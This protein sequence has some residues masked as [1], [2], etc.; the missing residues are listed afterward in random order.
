MTS[1]RA[2][3]IGDDCG[4]SESNEFDGWKNIIIN[5]GQRVVTYCETD[6]RPPPTV[7]ASKCQFI[8]CHSVTS[9]TF[10]SPP[11]NFFEKNLWMTIQPSSWLFLTDNRKTASRFVC[12]FA[13][14]E[15]LL[16]G[17]NPH[18]LIFLHWPID[19]KLMVGLD[20]NQQ[21]QWQVKATFSEEKVLSS[22]CQLAL[23]FWKKPVSVGFCW[24]THAQLL[25][26]QKTWTS[27]TWLGCPFQFLV[28]FLNGSK[29]AIANLTTFLAH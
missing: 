11:D 8:V 14:L 1:S 22:S 23:D 16:N 7:D 21:K 9:T 12:V 4:S 27:E 25:L 5:W 15:N 28:A 19:S 20:S 17:I 2:N 13:Q 3:N 26:Y 6:W 24:M 10:G 29:N 18:K